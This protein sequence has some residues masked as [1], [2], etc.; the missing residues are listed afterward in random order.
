MLLVTLFLLLIN[1]CFGFLFGHRGPAYNDLK[2]TYSPNIFNKWTFDSLPRTLNDAVKKGWNLLKDGCKETPDSLPGQRFIL[3]GDFSAILVFDAN[4]FIAGLQLGA[5]EITIDPG[6]YIKASTVIWDS[7]HYILSTY[8]VHPT[9][10]CDPS[11]S[12]TQAEFDQQ[13]TAE[14]VYLQVGPNAAFDLMDIPLTQ[15]EKTLSERHWIKGNCLPWMGRHYF[16]NTTLDMDCDQ[17]IPYCLLYNGGKLNGFCFGLNQ[18]DFNN[19]NPH[20]FEH[21]RGFQATVVAE[22][23]C[24]GKLPKCMNRKDAY[25]TSMHVYLD[26]TPY[27]NFC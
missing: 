6:R 4:G 16:F 20:R 9:R 8:F 15:D 24:I 13:G 19:A 17:W 7:N 21:A 14:K 11:K 2:V 10:I 5:P 26:S 27:L 22:M 18:A 23:C 1:C 12:R 25:T 3:N